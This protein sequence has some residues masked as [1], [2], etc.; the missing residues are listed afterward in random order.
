MIFPLKELHKEY[1]LVLNPMRLNWHYVIWY[2]NFFL[3]IV[4]LIV[5]FILLLFWNYHTSKTVIR[6]DRSRSMT[7]SQN[8][9]SI[10]HS[11][12]SELLN[13]NRTSINTSIGLPS[14]KGNTISIFVN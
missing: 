11:N 4:S 6:R 3:T 10:R 7:S 2:K 14:E 8:A 12:A 9:M 13:R 5:P 1:V